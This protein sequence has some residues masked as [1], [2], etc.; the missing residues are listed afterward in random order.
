MAAVLAREVRAE[1]RAKER[2]SPMAFFVLLT[3]M[4]F[5][6]AFAQAGLTVDQVGPGVLWTGVVFACLLGLGRSF[7]GEQQNRCIDA[8]LL[9]PLDRGALYVGK[10][11]A[12]LLSLLA[13]EALA[14][15]A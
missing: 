1:W 12:N 3:T 7:A 9:A 4:V 8:L 15:L 10:M 14:V 6:F 11:L 13:V 2:L 5:S